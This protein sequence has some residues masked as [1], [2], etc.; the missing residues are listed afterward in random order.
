MGAFAQV[1]LTDLMVVHISVF[2]LSPR[3]KETAWEFV[4][5]CTLNEDT[6]DWWI[7]Y[8]QGDTVSLKSALEKHK[9]DENAIYG[10]EKLYQ[11]WL[12]AGRRH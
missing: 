7:D 1:L 8:S 3:E 12:K 10:G 9:D 6:A 11:F 4:K 5:F 2:L